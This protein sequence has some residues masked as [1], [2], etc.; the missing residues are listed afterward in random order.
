M[1]HVCT[2]QITAGPPYLQSRDDRNVTAERK[3]NDLCYLLFLTSKLIQKPE[4]RTNADIVTW[5]IRI[6]ETNF[7]SIAAL[8]SFLMVEIETNN[9]ESAD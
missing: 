5:E 4:S 6:L 7:A 8:H 3:L 1:L 9:R 2:E